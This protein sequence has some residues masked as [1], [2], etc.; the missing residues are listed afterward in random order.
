V[1]Q[2]P[3]TWREVSQ[4]LVWLLPAIARAGKRRLLQEDAG[5]GKYHR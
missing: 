4:G 1:V 2:P 5:A 3:R